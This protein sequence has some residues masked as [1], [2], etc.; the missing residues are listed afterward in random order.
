LLIGDSGEKIDYT[1]AQCCNPIPGDEV[2]GFVTINEGIKIHK[3][4]CPNAIQ[5][6][7]N[8]AY[9]VVKAKWT[10][11]EKLSFLTG[12]VVKGID[13]V[14]VVNKITK[15]ISNQMKVNMRSLSFD[16]NDGVFEGKIT[17]FVQ[18]TSHLQ[19]LIGKLKEIPAVISVERID[20]A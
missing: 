11:G 15:L 10:G 12:I 18:D 2:F 13:D 9:R 19:E 1:L 20:Q 3:I 17:L 8:Y 5:L 14:G 6:L 4:T 16:S 7:S